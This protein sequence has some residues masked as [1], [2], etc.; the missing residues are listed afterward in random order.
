MNKDLVRQIAVVATLAITLAVN[1]LANIIP[2]NG[3]TTGEVSEKYLTFFTPVNET[4]SIWGAIYVLLALYAG[5]QALKTQRDTKDLVRTGW[6]F[7]AASLLNSLWMFMWHYDQI[8]LSVAV[9]L[10][11]LACLIVI[12]A[13]LGIGMKK[14]SH[15]RRLMVH[16]PF[17]VYL[18]WISVATIANISSA[19]AKLEWTAWGIDPELWGSL[20]AIIAGFIAVVVLF[21]RHDYA[22][23]IVIV[24]ALIGIAIKFD[25]YVFISTFTDLTA[26]V[27]VMT[28]PVAMVMRRRLVKM[29]RHQEPV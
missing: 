11:L 10:A 5:Y 12:Y 20:M 16:L 24:W 2:F 27:V 8:Y 26:L 22:Y 1:A 14:I 13:R 25:T 3:I 28:V 29:G 19:L 17:S 9:M 18:G 21:T 15:A 6:W 4:F 23:A 7:V